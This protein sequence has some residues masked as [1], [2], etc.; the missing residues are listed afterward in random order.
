MKEYAVS[1]NHASLLKRY[2]IYYKFSSVTVLVAFVSL[3]ILKFPNILFSFAILILSIV[4]ATG[5]YSKKTKIDNRVSVEKKL[6]DYFENATIL[7][8]ARFVYKE[9]QYHMEYL[10]FS[11]SGNYFIKFD[12]ARGIITGSEKED[13]LTHDINGKKTKKSIKKINNPLSE[14]EKLIKPFQTICKS[15]LGIKIEVEPVIIYINDY[16]ILDIQDESH[17]VHIKK[18]NNLFNRLNMEINDVIEYDKINFE[19]YEVIR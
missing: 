2:N 5:F 11:E 1:K 3:F 14:M 4:M 17:I 10:V 13:F 12:T 16:C 18:I 8:D 6:F 7:R 19:S 15:N 9:E